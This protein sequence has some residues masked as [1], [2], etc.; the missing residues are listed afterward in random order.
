[1]VRHQFSL[2]KAD[3][4][5]RLDNGL[6]IRA[7]EPIK[8]VGDSANLHS[9]ELRIDHLRGKTLLSGTAA[10]ANLPRSLLVNSI[11]AP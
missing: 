5:I 11:N 8:A 9:I 6:R 4:D 2:A 3:L 1:M 10:I 7:G